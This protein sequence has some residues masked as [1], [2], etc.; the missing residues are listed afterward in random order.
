VKKFKLHVHPYI[1]AFINKGIFSLKWEW[2]L[3]YSMGMRVIPDQ[4]LGFL[5]YKFYDSDKEELDLEHE[6]TVSD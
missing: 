6:K 4:S 1:A 3:K 5:E 2:K